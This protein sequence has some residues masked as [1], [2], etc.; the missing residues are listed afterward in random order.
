MV[1]TALS[2]A[3]SFI[4]VSAAA[5]P[6]DRT[7]SSSSEKNCYTGAVVRFPPEGGLIVDDTNLFQLQADGTYRV[8]RSCLLF[9]PSRHHEPR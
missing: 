3:L 4:A 1:R 8:R 5:Q 6:N 7:P 2:I 9:R